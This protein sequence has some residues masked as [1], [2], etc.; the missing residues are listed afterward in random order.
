MKN[1]SN[2][3]QITLLNIQEFASFCYLITTA[4]AIY[5]THYRK[6]TVKNNSTM[7]TPEE[8]RR[9]NIFNHFAILILT[10]IF[11]YVNFITLQSARENQEDTTLLSLQSFASILTTIGAIIVLYVVIQDPIDNPSSNENPGI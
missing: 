10:S 8:A 5:L 2:I 9:L 7:I 11:L 4:I 1:S 6:Q 3:D